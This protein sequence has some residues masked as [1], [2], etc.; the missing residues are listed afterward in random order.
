ML[1]VS[2]K[3]TYPNITLQLA[4]QPHAH[5]GCLSLVKR[6]VMSG[7]DLP[8]NYSSYPVQLS[9][10]IISCIEIRPISLYMG[11]CSIPCAHQYQSHPFSTWK[12]FPYLMI[13]YLI[14]IMCTAYVIYVMTFSVPLLSFEW[15]LII[16][17]FISI[18]KAVF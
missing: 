11:P 4:P 15:K 18:S 5:R 13:F 17:F 16:L 9:Y 1:E 8:P 12:H 10:K 6:L 3:V 7:N 14:Q 2:L